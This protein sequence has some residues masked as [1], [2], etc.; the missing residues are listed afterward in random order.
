[1]KV[2]AVLLCLMLT[3]A[4]FSS[5]VLAQPDAV[6]SPVT[7]CYTLTSKK[8]PLKRLMSYREVTSSKCPKEAVIFT[9]VLNKEICADPM[10]KW[11]QEYLATMNQKTGLD[12]NPAALGTA[13]PANTNFTTQEPAA[14]S[15]TTSFLSK[16]SKTSI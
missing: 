13:T 4:A 11:V 3:V 6:N 12:Q 10:Q 16:N 7:C 8:I 2:S 15:S 1:M 9:T 5:L 14:S